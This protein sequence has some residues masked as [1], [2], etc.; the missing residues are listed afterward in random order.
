[1]IYVRILAFFIFLVISA[2]AKLQLMEWHSDNWPRPFL[3]PVK[4]GKTPQ[5]VVAQYLRLI[6]TT[7]EL[8]ELLWDAK[9]DLGSSRF[10]P[11]EMT[12]S[13]VLLLAN[14]AQD[15]TQNSERV[16][17]LS[18]ILV[19][20]KRSTYLLPVAIVGILSGKEKQEFY[21]LV[22][23]KFPV[24][25]ALGG[26]DVDPK[27]YKSKNF[28]SHPQ[29][30]VRDQ[31]EISFIQNYYRRGKGFIFGICRG[32]Q[33]TAVALGYKL[34]Q[35]IP[36]Q[37]LNPI[38]HQNDYHALVFKP[39]RNQMLSLAVGVD[40]NVNVKSIHH[41]SVQFHHDG[42]LEIAALSEDGV[43]EALEDKHGKALLVQFHPE[44]MIEP[45][46]EKIISQT[47]EQTKKNQRRSC[48]K[49]Y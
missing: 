16:N 3:I 22:A 46:G 29:S 45:I 27:Y 14:R 12:G 37:I 36:F 38:K 42:P 30:T 8:A 28:H 18:K 7:P 23:D 19:K 47:L 40:K 49:F 1:M 25:F 32:A 5:Q 41:Q 21:D 2:H 39:T 13:K 15:Y 48:F 17:N 9:I 43:V 26:D 33:L 4:E 44:L 20:D 24:A 34:I 10:Y 31:H 6:D 11:L 35:D